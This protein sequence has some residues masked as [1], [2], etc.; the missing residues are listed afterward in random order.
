MGK[1]GT[2][3]WLGLSLA[4]AAGA[5]PHSVASNKDLTSG[6]DAAVFYTTAGTSSQR[7]VF[8][9]FLANLPG[10]DTAISITNA[11][12]TPWPNFLP[13]DFFGGGNTRG[14]V[15][16]YLYEQEGNLTFYETTTGS[17]GSGLDPLDGTLGPGQ[18]YTVLL[19]E[20]LAAATG[21][22]ERTE[23]EFVGHA[24]IVSNFDA[25][26]GTYNVTIFGV[27]FT[28]NFALEPTM[29]TG[30]LFGGIPVFQPEE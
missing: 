28:Q 12:A 2:F 14:T 21:V 3:L 9:G 23:R 17:P 7:A 6:R 15:E 22:T 26:Q 8:A 25:V 29:G 24:W 5:I 11:L 20:L 19:D 18:T 10:V 1:L 30:L 4:A 16:F 13:G 27:G